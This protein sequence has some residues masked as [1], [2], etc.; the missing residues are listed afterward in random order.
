M[1]HPTKLELDDLGDETGYQGRTLERMVR[2][3][4]VLQAI[5]EDGFLRDRLALK[6]G[7][8]LNAFHLD[9]PR[10][11]VDIDLNYI[12]PLDEGAMQAERG[13]VEAGVGRIL[14]DQGYV[15]RD[16]R[17]KRNGTKWEMQFDSALGGVGGLN[18]DLGFIDRQPLFG[19][20]RMSSTRIG[21][22]RATD[23]LVLDRDE[24]IAGKLA[25]L[26]ERTLARDLFDGLSIMEAF[27][28]YDRVNVKAALLMF[29]ASSRVP[30]GDIRIAA[31]ESNLQRAREQIELCL[32]AGY[33]DERGGAEAWFNEGIRICD[34]CFGHLMELTESE[35][36]FRKDVST[37]GEVNAGL[38]T[39]PAG[40]RARIASSPRLAATRRRVLEERERAR[41]SPAPRRPRGPRGPSTGF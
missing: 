28:D 13:E 26:F 21:R 33:L 18:I 19:A 24:V 30:W 38:V 10:L 25:A 6:G 8:G 29:I 22:W 4:G 9:L 31:N 3:F 37:R 39:A 15:V 20:S 12:G 11:S 1:V 7:T 35:A 36:E 27:P 41:T 23:V 14:V 16:G 32:P 40:L 5:A 17:P 34:G 2:L